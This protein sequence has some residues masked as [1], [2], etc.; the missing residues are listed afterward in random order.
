MLLSIKGDKMNKLDNE[1]IMT[2]DDTLKMLDQMLEK[3]DKEWWDNFYKNKDK[4]IPFFTEKPDENLAQYMIQKDSH[5][6]KTLDIGCG[7]GRNSIFL[8]KLG[9]VSKGIDLSTESIIWARENAKKSNLEVDFENIS[10]FDFKDHNQNY[11][12]IHDSGCLHHIKPHR[13][14]EYLSKIHSLLKIDGH[15]SLVCFNLNGGSNLSDFEVYEQKSMQGGLGFSSEK[16][17][18][19]LSPYFNILEIRT[20]SA[21]QNDVFGTD[22]C[23]A[24]IMSKKCS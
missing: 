22:I 15:F 3:W 23:W 11:I 10:F 17:S 16:L 2:N 14:A 19:V 13:R 1:I 18:A 20:M 21:E 12:H 9:Y 6:G 24:V 4:P 7:N 8:A 5:I